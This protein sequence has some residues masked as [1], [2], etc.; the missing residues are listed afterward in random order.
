MAELYQLQEQE[1]PEAMTQLK[2][3]HVN[4]KKVADYC[5]GLYLQAA[6]KKPALEETRG[7]TT[8]ALASVAYQINTLATSFL[9][10]LDLQ[11]RQLVDMESSINHLS[12]TVTIHKEKVARKEI[13]VLTTSKTIHRPVGVKSPGIIFPV[14][15]EK[16]VKYIR[17]PIDY[18]ILD[19]VGS[20]GPRTAVSNYRPPSHTG[21]VS[22]TSSG[23]R[24][25]TTNVPRHNVPTSS[26]TGTLALRSAAQRQASGT[27]AP[28]VRPPEVPSHYM[29]TQY[30]QT[31]KPPSFHED[32]ACNPTYGYAPELAAP[33]A[34][35][36]PPVPPP[37]PPVQA[38]VTERRNSSPY[39]TA[40]QAMY[41][42]NMG[43]PL[44]PPPP[45]MPDPDPYN[46]NE[47]SAPTRDI[48]RYYIPSRD[49]VSMPFPPPLPEASP[50]VD[51]PW[52]P[53]SYMEKVV[54]LFD[55][56][57][58]NDDELRFRENAVLYVIKKNEDGWWEGVMESDNGQS[59]CGLFP[60]NYVEPL[61]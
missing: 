39:Q 35:P 23:G 22:S 25:N 44:S 29:P 4:L 12:Q 47:V 8:Q 49:R 3:G 2:D 31:N 1:I 41:N 15:P 9:S 16:V 26:V 19:S 27:I 54:A 24:A 43:P 14:Q 55:Y 46:T 40:G 51:P 33:P 11:A 58:Q 18:T 21:S 56:E 17:K 32:I 6:E 5:E 53:D 57:P 48:F 52:A 34:P 36:G 13:G 37:V 20:G 10:L 59:I 30:L 45:P 38:I 50:S 7:Y 61:L 42:G 60:E 28:P